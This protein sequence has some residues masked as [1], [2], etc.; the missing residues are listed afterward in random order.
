MSSEPN[1]GPPHLV[2]PALETLWKH[3]LDNWDDERAH[4]MFLEHC[5]SADRLVEAAVR[6]RGMSADRDRGEGA[7]RHLGAV[8]LLALARL[9]E[10]RS[11]PPGPGSRFARWL[12][13]AAFAVASGLVLAYLRAR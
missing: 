11:P 3:V 1:D 7:K 4:A 5:R 13:V 2:D 6:Y 9:D 8:T 10:H 12:L